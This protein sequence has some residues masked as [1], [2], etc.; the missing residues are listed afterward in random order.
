[1]SQQE[2]T[3]AKARAAGIDGA[4]RGAGL[5]LPEGVSVPAEQLRRLLSQWALAEV[6]P[7][8]L[9]PWLP[10]AY[11]FGTVVYFT[12]AHEPAWWAAIAAALAGL[13]VAILACRNSIGFPLA[14]GVAA[15]PMVAP[16]RS[17]ERMGG[18]LCWR[19]AATPSRSRNG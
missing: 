16:R 14:L 13:I 2:Q 7:G 18:S 17:G 12:A 3:R 6:A 15:M 8:R 19:A 10:V 1:M 5:V 4:R 11:G 9:M